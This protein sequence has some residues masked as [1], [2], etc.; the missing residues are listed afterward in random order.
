MKSTTYRKQSMPH[1]CDPA[2]AAMLA[3]C[4]L[5]EDEILIVPINGGPAESGPSATPAKPAALKDD[6]L[7]AEL[8]KLHP[9]GF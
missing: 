5:K 2:F 4:G 6:A 1:P 8:K 3:S 7:L 9:N